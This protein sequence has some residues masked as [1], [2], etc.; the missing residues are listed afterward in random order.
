MRLYR[1]SDQKFIAALPD[2]TQNTSLVKITA[3]ANPVAIYCYVKKAVMD[4]PFTRPNFFKRG[5]SIWNIQAKRFISSSIP[6]LTTLYDSDGIN[7]TNLAFS[8]DGTKILS[9][10]P[11]YSANG[12]GRKIIYTKHLAPFPDDAV[13]IKPKEAQLLNEI[14][15][16]IIKLPFL[17]KDL[18]DWNFFEWDKAALSQDQKFFA[19]ASSN[20]N[21]TIWC[22]D[23]P[24]RQLKWKY[25]QELTFPHMLMFSP[26]GTMVAVAGDNINY[27]LNGLS[28]LNVIDAKTGKLIHSYTEQSLNQQIRDRIRIYFLQKLLRGTSKLQRFAN[29]NKWRDKISMSLNSPPAPGNSG[30]IQDIA[31]SPDNK[32]LAASYE[33]GSVKIW[34]VKE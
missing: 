23:I 24:N 8:N 6:H 11:T 20:S 5:Y 14:N 9:L 13:Q 27:R 34:R 33:D 16:K 2:V 32:S 19:A 3:G 31:W 26:D 17:H 18:Y 25:S 21:G 29:T 4:D 30:Q 7:P 1:V 15:G 12:I 22:Y 28:F 10:W